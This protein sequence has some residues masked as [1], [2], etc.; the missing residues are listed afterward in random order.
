MHVETIACVLV[1]VGCV[2]WMASADVASAVVMCYE[3]KH[4]GGTACPFGAW[5]AD[6]D[7]EKQRATLLA[8]GDGLSLLLCPI[9][10]PHFRGVYSCRAEQV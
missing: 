2:N 8:V 6:S 10:G 5:V 4:Y 9:S 3:A 1:G 7:R